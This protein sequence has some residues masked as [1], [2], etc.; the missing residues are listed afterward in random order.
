MKS[1]KKV[2]VTLLCAAL[3]VFASVMGTM[4]YLTDTKAVNNTFTVGSVAITLNE[5][6]VDEYGVPIDG[7]DRVIENEYKLIPGHKYT[8][9]PLVEV[10][11]GSEPSFLFVKVENGL[12]AIESH[13]YKGATIAEQLSDAGWV[14]LD[15]VENVYY[16][17]EIVDARNGAV[18]KQ[19]FGAL[20]ID[21]DADVSAYED[22]TIKVT[23][24]A[25]Q[26][27]GFNGDAAAAWK[28][29]FAE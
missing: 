26:A 11:K 14:K 12:E 15:G 22:A 23:A 28:A 16:H 24:Y 13:A 21:K 6:D 7:A 19:V 5:A 2:L 1:K 3:L 8:K 4:A 9:D 10:A 25:V 17:N 18:A 27:D 29:A 20:V